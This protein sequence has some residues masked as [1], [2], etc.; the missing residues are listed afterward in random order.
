[1]GSVA[2]RLVGGLPAAAKTN[3]STPRQ[4]VGLSFGIND[5]KIAFDTQ[6]TIVVYGDLGCRQFFLL[7]SSRPSYRIAQPRSS[8]KADGFKSVRT[9]DQYETRSIF[10]YGGVDFVR[11]GQY[12]AL[13]IQNFAE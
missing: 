3:R 2:K 13:E 7:D 8:S 11:P 6:G 5:L 10:R 9:P 1:M 12:A 4:S